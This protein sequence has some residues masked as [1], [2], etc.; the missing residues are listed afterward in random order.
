MLEVEGAKRRSKML[1]LEPCFAHDL[2]N[3]CHR[4]QEWRA[5][6]TSTGARLF[7]SLN[8]DTKTGH[9][10]ASFPSRLG[11]ADSQREST[12]GRSAQGPLRSSPLRGTPTCRVLRHHPRRPGDGEPAARGVLK[13]WAR[14][15]D[16]VSE[17]AMHIT[18]LD[19]EQVSGQ[20]CAHLPHNSAAVAAAA[21]AL[22]PLLQ[23]PRELGGV[24]QAAQGPRPPRA[25]GGA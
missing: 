2:V 12:P 13:S 17:P 9:W 21:T 24:R 14:A 10:F 11:T 23:G 19:V 1:F 8:S 4:R 16:R 18:Q 15:A 22:E 20:G 3:N 6:K 7:K 25:R 5:P